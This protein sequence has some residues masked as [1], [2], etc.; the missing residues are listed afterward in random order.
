MSGPGEDTTAQ[1]AYVGEAGL[2]E[3]S[4]GGGAARAEVAIDDDIA[5]GVQFL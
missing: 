1:V 3:E 2:E 4:C 5:E